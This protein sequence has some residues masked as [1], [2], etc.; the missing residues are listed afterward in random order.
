MTDVEDV[1]DDAAMTFVNGFR[2]VRI[3]IKDAIESM[4]NFGGERDRALFDLVAVNGFTYE[5]AG[6]Q[7]GMSVR[8]ARYRY[9][10][11][12]ER[13]LDFLAKKGIKNLEDLL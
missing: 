1:L 2:D 6:A 7:L 4:E 12:V 8:Q 9:G 3:I 11:A 10:L 13:I 5:E